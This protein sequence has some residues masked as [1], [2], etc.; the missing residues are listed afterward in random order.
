MVS[1]FLSIVFFAT[2]LELYCHKSREELLAL[3]E[4]SSTPPKTIRKP[5]QPAIPSAFQ[6]NTQ[7]ATYLLTFKYPPGL[8]QSGLRVYWQGHILKEKDGIFQLSAEKFRGDFTIA[9]AMIKTPKQPSIENF[10]VPAGVEYK[11]YFLHKKVFINDPKKYEWDIKELK[12]NEGLSLDYDTLIIFTDP[13]L[14]GKV[15]TQNWEKQSDIIMLPTFV[16]ANSPDLSDASAKA[17]LAALD[18][19]LF[20]TKTHLETSEQAQVHITKVKQS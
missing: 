16:F 15:E 9:V 20:H 5:S 2:C 8:E 12:G 11:R 7:M 19:D 4:K 10:E 18:T 17:V 13:H 3:Y 14:I 1:L 6:K